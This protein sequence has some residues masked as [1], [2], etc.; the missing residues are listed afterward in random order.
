MMRWHNGLR[1]FW[2]KVF[3]SSPIVLFLI[4]I[5][6]MGGG[7]GLAQARQT[8]QGIAQS[9]S[10]LAQLK[11]VVPTVDPL[12]N[13]TVPQ[14]NPEPTDPPNS[15]PLVPG[16]V[17]P[18]LPRYRLGQQLYRDSCGTCHLAIS[19]AVFPSETWRR[20]LQET[21]QHYGAQLP[22]LIDP[23]RLLIWNY[24]STY[25]RP[26]LTDEEPPY[27]LKESRYFRALHPKVRLP[28]PPTLSGCVTCHPS[29]RD[30]NFRQLSPE[31]QSQ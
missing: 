4:V 3:K 21:G 30:Y 22:P 1:S 9:Q 11:P 27:R 17:D 28:D 14:V 15:L 2:R 31:W 29:A 25:S 6:S 7:W 12:G 26:L 20:L 24:L 18:V 16:T 19:P 5:L 10:G 23:P 13:P 8:P